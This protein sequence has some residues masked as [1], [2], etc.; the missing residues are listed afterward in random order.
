MGFLSRGTAFRSAATASDARTQLL[1]DGQASGNAIVRT[2]QHWVCLRSFRMLRRRLRLARI[3]AE[4]VRDVRQEPSCFVYYPSFRH[5]H[6]S[7]CCAEGLTAAVVSDRPSY[8]V[9][10]HLSVCTFLGV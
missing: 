7:R 2:L 9:W 5:S 10:D 4:G 8:V 6:D 3:R 1:G